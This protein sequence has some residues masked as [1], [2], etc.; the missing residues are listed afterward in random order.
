MESSNYRLSGIWA[1]PQVKGM[2]YFDQTL[3]NLAQNPCSGVPC[4]SPAQ[5]C[6]LVEPGEK[7][8]LGNRGALQ[9][10]P[11]EKV[12]LLVCELLRVARGW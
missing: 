6:A 3:G 2:G 8:V 5:D 11:A 9:G 4:F 7:Q 1:R 12:L 10:G